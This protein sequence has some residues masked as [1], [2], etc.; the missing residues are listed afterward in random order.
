[1]SEDGLSPLTHI[2]HLTHEDYNFIVLKHI[3]L[4]LV[5]FFTSLDPSIP[6][7]LFDFD[8]LKEDIKGRNLLFTSPSE[9]MRISSIF[10]ALLRGPSF[11]RLSLTCL[12]SS[13]VEYDM[14]KMM[15]IGPSSKAIGQYLKQMTSF[16]HPGAV[17]SCVRSKGWGQTI[18]TDWLICQLTPSCVT[19]VPLDCKFY[20]YSAWLDFSQCFHRLT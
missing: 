8:T 5:A 14:S 9:L 6:P 12:I 13:A 10:I 11:G 16:A 7:G 17:T 4:I 3:L 15:V 2:A 20:R 1:M 18:P 19:P